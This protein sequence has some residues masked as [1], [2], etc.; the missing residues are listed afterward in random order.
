MKAFLI[1][2]D[3]CNGCYNC[4]IACKDEHCGTQWLPYAAEQPLTGQFWC[5]I[6][7]KTRGRVPVVKVSYKPVLCAHCESA[8]CV[9]A[10]P[11]GAVYRRDDGL[12]IVNPEKAK[13]HREIVDA[14]PL[15]AIYW[16]EELA[17]PQKCTGCAHLLDDGWEVPRCVDA[18][19]TDALRFGEEFELDLAG[20]ELLDEVAGLGGRVWYKNLPK[21]FVAG[22]LVDFA[23]DE[24]VIDADVALFDSDGNV[25]ARTR[26]NEFGDFRFDQIEPD[27]YRVDAVLEGYAV[28]SCG[29]DARELDVV[30]GDLAFSR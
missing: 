5:R 26:T 2:V 21:R 19:A 28:L 17:L 1:D 16:N 22:C 23:A 27:D 29:A 20:A 25:V 11:E 4:Q 8:P 10:A 3:R 18:C 30:L 6:D 13:G 9:A 12:V 15:G 14:C 24:V 7:E